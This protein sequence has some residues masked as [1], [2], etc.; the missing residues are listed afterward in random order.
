[1]V[2]AHIFF[3]FLV[4]MAIA[5]V[6]SL[7]FATAI[8]FLN[9]LLEQIVIFTLGFVQT[10]FPV[11]LGAGLSRVYVLQNFSETLFPFSPEITEPLRLHKLLGDKMFRNELSIGFG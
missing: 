7:P 2:G 3:I 4:V 8:S 1:M 11:F 5:A 9:D 6:D 10:V